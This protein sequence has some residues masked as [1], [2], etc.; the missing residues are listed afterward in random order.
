MDKEFYTS[1]YHL[2]KQFQP[3]KITNDEIRTA[4]KVANEVIAIEQKE[5]TFATSEIVLL[6]LLNSVA[7]VFYDIGCYE[8]STHSFSILSGLQYQLLEDSLPYSFVTYSE[9]VKSTDAFLSKK[10]VSIAVPSAVNATSSIFLTHE[11]SHALKETN[12]QEC[13]LIYN[14]NEM[15]PMLIEL[16]AGYVR[17]S[18]VFKEVVLSR[19]RLLYGEAVFFKKVMGEIKKCSSGKI[20]AYLYS[21]LGNSLVY[22]NSFY[23]T[24]ALFHVYLS[25]PEYIVSF[26]DQVLNQEMSSADVLHACVCSDLVSSYEE[27]FRQGLETIQKL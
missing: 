13:K 4:W 26:I 14:L 18:A 17:G 21:A 8:A 5:S 1:L 16:I 2:Q 10:A 7:S 23:Y 25:Y 27:E 22:L 3:N 20:P 6:D 19:F 15:I 9:T 11:V 24:V 12:P